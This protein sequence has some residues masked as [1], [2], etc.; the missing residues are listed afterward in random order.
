MNFYLAQIETRI[1]QWDF[2][3]K[4]ILNQ[5]Q[6]LHEFDAIFFPANALSGG[7]LHDLIRHPHF[8]K[9]LNA[10]LKELTRI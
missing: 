8:E 1:F 7:P 4:E 10:T 6:N 3:L 5:Y 9:D 2:N